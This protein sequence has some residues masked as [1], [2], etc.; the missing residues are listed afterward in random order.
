MSPVDTAAARHDHGGVTEELAL[1]A[2]ALLDQFEPRMRALAA[3]YGEQESTQD[4]ESVPAGAVGSSCGWCPVCAV[5]AALRGH[6]P[7]LAARATEHVLGLITLARL[8]LAEQ[9]A[10]A[11]ARPAPSDPPAPSGP[12]PA[13][14]A[15][16][17]PAPP[18]GAPGADGTPSSPRA[19]RVHRITIDRPGPPG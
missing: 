8:A 14:Q 7:E 12:P 16:A 1:L 9:A 11:A 15:T 2:A 5:A 13:P 17:P 18:A 4:G 3:R 6:H 10:R 19:R